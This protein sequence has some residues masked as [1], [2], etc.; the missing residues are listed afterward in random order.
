MNNYLTFASIYDMFMDNINYEDWVDYL[1]KI[2]HKYNIK[3]GSI[4]ELGCGTGNITI[5]LAKLGYNMTGIDLSDDMLSVAFDKSSKSNLNILFINQNMVDFKL[6]EKTEVIISLCDS[7]NYLLE[8]EELMMTFKAVEENL[9]DN[10]IFIFDLNTKYYYEEILADNT[11]A[12]NRENASIIWEN[13]FYEKENINAIDLTMFL[14]DNNNYYKKYEEEHLRRAYD[15]EFVTY[16]LNKA[17]L[18]VVNIYDAFTFN[19]ANSKSERIYFIV[20]K[21]S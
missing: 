2:L 5:P 1:I 11:M 12:E 15:I 4:V 18:E 6:G 3:D 20:K 8:E 17:N 16:L 9:Q 13:T 21:I 14:L 19:K 10:G 7:I